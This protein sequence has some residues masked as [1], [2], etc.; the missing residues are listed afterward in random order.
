MYHM[1]APECQTQFISCQASDV[2][3]TFRCTQFRFAA[4]RPIRC[5]NKNERVTPVKPG[6]H[7]FIA[8][9]RAASFSRKRDTINNPSQDQTI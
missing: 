2:S 6:F 8:R 5:L 9:H 3:S 7:F 1:I 4:P